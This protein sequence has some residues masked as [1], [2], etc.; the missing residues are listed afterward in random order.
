VARC[1]GNSLEEFYLQVS[2]MV[3]ERYFV[4]DAGRGISHA[5]VI[6]KAK[7]AGDRADPWRCGALSLL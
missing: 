7:E 1:D 3:P 4:G 2:F 5:R 6:A